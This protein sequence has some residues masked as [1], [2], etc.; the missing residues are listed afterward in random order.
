MKVYLKLAALSLALLCGACQPDDGWQ[1]LFNGK[2]FTGFKQL[3]GKAPYRVEN[4]CMVGK[5]VDKEP[6]SFMATEQMYGDFILEFEVKCHPDLNSG[7]QFR[8]ESKPD[9][10]KGRV[11]GYQCEIDPSDRAWSGGLYDEARRGW[12]I[13][14]EDNPA[15]RAAYKKDDWNKFRVEAI[16]NSI[17][18][19][20][21]GVN[22]VNV[23]D[24]MTLEGLIGFQVHGIFGKK[25]N[26]G[27]EIWWRNIR[28]K[29]EDL[30]ASRMKGELVPEVN[31]T[32]NSVSEKEKAEGWK[33][34]F[35][36]KTSNGWRGAGK[37]AFPEN[38]WKIEN[39]ILSVLS[40]KDCPERGGDIVT[41]DEYDAFEFSFEFKLTKGANSGVKYMIQESEK[42]KGF[43]IGPEFQV[44]DDG[45]HPDAKQYTSYPGSR[46]AASLYDIIAASD[47]KKVYPSSWGE[48]NKGVIKKFPNNHVEHWI[49]GKKVVEYDWASDAFLELVKGS[50]FAKDAYNEFGP[51]GTAK[52]GRILLQDHQDEVKY[53]SLKIREL[54]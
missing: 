47:G 22:T 43:V 24:D 27:K 26:I 12:L 19:W 28:I 21:N 6:N 50:K 8:S 15:G 31:L 49:N 52:K 10:Q 14:L 36:G 51:F 35:D 25:E 16:G 44:L 3:N 37:D 48:W 40:S 46:T 4:G 1:Q 13:N 30:E 11:H 38:G 54:K 41:V 34:L 53:R 17:R 29:T 20:L 5:T 42:S 2:D 9:Y 7:V 18:I 45:T 32:P 33:L 23:L 39:G